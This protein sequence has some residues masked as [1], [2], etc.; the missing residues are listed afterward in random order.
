MVN[1]PRPGTCN[2]SVYIVA[3]PRLDLMLTVTSNFLPADN[4][5]ISLSELLIPGMQIVSQRPDSQFHD[6]FSTTQHLGGPVFLTV[7]QNQNCQ[8][9]ALEI[10]MPACTLQGSPLEI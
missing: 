1:T 7:T 3:R 8:L 9:L 5:K 4:T 6:Q 2:G 10:L